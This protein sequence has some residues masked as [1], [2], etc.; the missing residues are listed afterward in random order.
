MKNTVPVESVV[1]CIFFPVEYKMSVDIYRDYE[2]GAGNRV[3][4]I[5]L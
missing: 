3:R 1:F 2:A 5:T 4:L